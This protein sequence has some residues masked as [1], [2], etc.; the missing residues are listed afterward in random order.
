ME[1]TVND[2]LT[3]YGK[4]I[5][6][7]K[8]TFYAVTVGDAQIKHEDS[9]LWFTSSGFKPFGYKGQPIRRKLA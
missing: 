9:N 1:L 3:S 7:L 4:E 2:I 5:K 6:Y 8:K